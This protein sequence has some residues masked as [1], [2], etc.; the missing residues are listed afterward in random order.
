MRFGEPVGPALQ[1]LNLLALSRCGHLQFKEAFFTQ[2]LDHYSVMR[3]T[4][5][6]QQRYFIGD[7]HGGRGSPIFVYIGNEGELKPE[8]QG[9]LWEKAPQFGAVLL[10]VEVRPELYVGILETLLASNGCC[11][12]TDF[13]SI[14][15]MGR[16]SLLDHTV[17]R[18][19]LAT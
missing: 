8:N 5:T 10:F 14:D 19:T 6:W 18:L 12:K 16:A 11:S 9:L 13:R 1:L 17:S 2:K 4:Q 15:T 3:P 7:T